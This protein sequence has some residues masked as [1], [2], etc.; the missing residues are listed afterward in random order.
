MYLCKVNY[1][2]E[3]M[4]FLKYIL[5][6]LLT[7]AIAKGVEPLTDYSNIE[8][9]GSAMP[10]PAP[11]VTAGTPDT[12]TPIMINHVGRHGSRFISNMK[13]VTL[14]GRALEAAENEKTITKRG[15]ELFAFTEDMIDRCTGRWGVLDTL[16]KAEEQGIAMRMYGDFMPLFRNGKIRAISSYMPRAI[17]S[18]YEFTHQ[19]A[20]LDNRVEITTTSGRCND[21]LLRFFDCK[22]QEEANNDGEIKAVIE[23]YGRDMLPFEPL[24]RVLGAGFSYDRFDKVELLMSMYTMIAG[25]PA[26]EVPVSVNQYFTNKEYNAIWSYFNLKQYLEHAASYI[27]DVPAHL[28]LPL[29]KD[30]IST[31]DTLVNGG[32]IA[33]VQLRF[34]HAETLMPL[35]SLIQVPGCSYQSRDIE[36]L[37]RNWMD[38]HIVPMAANFRMILFK[39][40]NTGKIYARFDL[41][42]IPVALF[43]GSEEIYIPWEDARSYLL[44][45]SGLWFSGEY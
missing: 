34:G 1:K 10:Y 9:S 23:E 26:M 38:F 22:E 43:E 20:R 31:A 41:N 42:E 13:A 8:C 3:I 11:M 2:K 27:T 15:R 37:S 19:I 30:I 14:V 7:P 40:K 35:L 16:G 4:K 18:M 17:M 39:S 29:L 5:V 33:P 12:L 44:L 28:S 32:D 24:D 36:A 45:R 25:S 21:G 6:L